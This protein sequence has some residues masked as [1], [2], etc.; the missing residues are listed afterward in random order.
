MYYHYGTCVAC[1][2]VLLQGIHYTVKLQGHY[3][4]TGSAHLFAIQVPSELG[5]EAIKYWIMRKRDL[6]SQR[7]T[8]PLAR[9]VLL[10][11]YVSPLVIKKKLNCLRKSY[12]NIFPMKSTY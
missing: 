2:L 7:F 3:E 4:Q 8:K 1:T 9:N 10:R 6:I 11:T 12:Q 5:L